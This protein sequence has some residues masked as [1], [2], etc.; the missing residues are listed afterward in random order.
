[1]A[2]KTPRTIAQYMHSAY[3]SCD[4]GPQ[5][6]ERPGRYFVSVRDGKRRALLCGP[7]PTRREALAMVEPVRAK[8]CEVDPR[9]P[10][11]AYG[12]ARLHDDEPERHGMLNRFFGCPSS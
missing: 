10:W 4:H 5:V 6:D 1:M 7:F 2:T 3:G 11:Y 12:T 8:A 9:G